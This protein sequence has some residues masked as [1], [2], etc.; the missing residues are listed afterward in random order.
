M[1][2]YLTF[3]QLKTRTKN[4]IRDFNNSMNDIIEDAINMVYLNEIMV[5]DRLHPLW[6]MMN[7]DDSLEAQAPVNI[8]NISKANPGIF[9]TDVPH[10]LTADEI[11]R[12]HV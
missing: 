12:A 8:V 1:T 3:G 7:L 5:Y 9:E 6:W 11:G 2:D 4:I 10:N